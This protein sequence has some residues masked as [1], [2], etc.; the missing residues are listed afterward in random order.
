MGRGRADGGTTGKN[1]PPTV[2]L[3]KGMDIRRTQKH[4]RAPLLLTEPTIALNIEGG[5][6]VGE[7]EWYT[8]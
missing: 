4:R 7:L 3:K 6:G 8:L 1:P 5:V 2:S